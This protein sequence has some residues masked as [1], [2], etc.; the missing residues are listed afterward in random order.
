MEARRNLSKRRGGFTLVELLGVVVI[1]AILLGLISAAALRARATAKVTMI[2]NEITQL[3]LACKAYKEKFGDFPPDFTDPAAV[4]RHMARAFPRYDASQWQ[5]HAKN[6]WGI[7]DAAKLDP[8]AA[9]TFFLGGYIDPIEKRPRGFSMNPE[10]PFQTPTSGSEGRHGPFFDFDPARLEQDPYNNRAWR[11]YAIGTPVGSGP[12]N[13]GAYFYFRALPEGTYGR[14]GDK[15]S[16]H[17]DRAGVKAFQNNAGTAYINPSTF[18]I[19]QAGL[20]LQFGPTEGALPPKYPAGTNYDNKG[21]MWDNITNFSGGTLEKA[22][23]GS[24]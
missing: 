8:S 18:Q 6:V 3:D 21:R 2:Y 4:T 24:Q 9:L 5:A 12:I 1:I 17:P 7:A 14:I 10:N 19:L 15:G 11:Y 13:D 16:P 23:Q 20:D 22:R